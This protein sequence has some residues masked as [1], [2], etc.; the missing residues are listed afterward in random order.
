VTIDGVN[1]QQ[2]ATIPQSNT[3][4]EVEV[5]LFAYIGQL[6]QLRFVWMDVPSANDT[7]QTPSL[8]LID[9]VLVEVTAPPLAAP[10]PLLPT[11][12][13]QPTLEPSP[14][15]FPTDLPTEAPPDVPAAS[16]TPEPPPAS[17][18]APPASEGGS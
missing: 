8:W 2:V 16:S 1:W 14:T 9:S 3:W 10:P 4:T 13:L 12:T 6:I 5:E 18:D 11:A 17:N 15:P 7:L